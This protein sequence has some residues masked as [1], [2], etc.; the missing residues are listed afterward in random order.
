[1]N[2]RRV[3]LVAALFLGAI[4]T[5]NAQT[6]GQAQLA[7]RALDLERSGNYAGA[8]NAYRAMLAEAP[9]QAGALLG[10]ERSLT[11]LS[12]LPEMMTDLAPV[13]AQDSVPGVVY[14]I[15]VRVL[16]AT[17]D[18]DRTAALVE[19][20]A[21]SVPG[22]EAPWQE[23]G[24]AAVARQDF[25][26][27]RRAFG[28]GRERL[29]GGA[30]S[31]ELA[32]LAS[33]EGHYPVAVREW[34]TTLDR[35]P[36]Y[37][38]GAVAMLGQAAPDRRP[39]VLRVLGEARSPI[40]ERLAAV[41]TA[42]W[43]DPL[44]GLT[45]LTAALP[46]EREERRAELEAFL[47]EVAGLPMT[48]GR[49]VEA[50]VHE[51]LAG[52]VDPEEAGGHWLE[53]AQAYSESGDSP[54]ARRM[55]GRLT[56]ASEV[57]REVASSAT[58]ALVGVLVD[59]GKLAEAEA[60]FADLREMLSTEE[61]ERLG[62]RLATGWLRAGELERAAVLAEADS[63]LEGFDLAGRIRLYQG[64]LLGAA[65]LLRVAGPFA[66]TRQ[67]A[68]TRLVYLA[69]LQVIAR[70]SVPGLGAALYQ[71]ELRD[72]VVAGRQ[73]ARVAAVLPPDA[74]GA[75]LL[76]MAGRILAEQDQLE[77]AE[78]LLIRAAATAAP[79]A[80]AGAALELARLEAGSGRATAARV[81]LEQLILAWPTSAVT[82]EARRML[83]QLRGGVPVGR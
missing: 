16:V 65:D 2:W 82:P 81:R 42:R 46:G 15:A 22:S 58:L 3:V 36:T 79:A 48:G 35:L 27:G 14:G 23:W 77:D 54:S 45:R 51:A 63:S 61:R 33:I 10:L 4:G 26:T 60:Q 5:A 70:D 30:L 52:L 69:L 66:G 34:I 57:P 80:A 13:L 64:D 49:L 62:R 24:M 1:M 75:E 53:A 32:Q 28:L 72:S 17:G 11:A 44:G 76:L 37:R 19:R 59:E 56:A 12:R 83:D 74:G 7:A 38:A 18:R 47:T 73:L 68:N 21:A 55:L 40:A 41:L 29:G 31:V 8:L 78:P 43:G 25:E 6:A 9:G 20:W 39:E 50:R 71:L 67:E